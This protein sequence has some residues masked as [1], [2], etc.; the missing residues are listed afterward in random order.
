MHVPLVLSHSWP[1]A[2]AAQATPP[3]PHFPVDCDGKGRQAPALQQPFGQ[4][5]SPHPW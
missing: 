5:T 4:V 2:Q 1:V 3:V